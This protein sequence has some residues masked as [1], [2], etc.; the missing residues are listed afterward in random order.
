MVEQ[1][2]PDGGDDIEE[3]YINIRASWYTTFTTNIKPNLY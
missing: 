3:C 2:E 1:T